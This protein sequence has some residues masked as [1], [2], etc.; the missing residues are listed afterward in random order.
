MIIESD[1]EDD[2]MFIKAK[3]RKSVTTTTTE[4]H[5]IQRKDTEKKNRKCSASSD[6]KP[7]AN[8]KYRECGSDSYDEWL[9]F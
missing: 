9:P 5:V 1:S 8:K 3:V 6:K 7:S 4:K 2:V